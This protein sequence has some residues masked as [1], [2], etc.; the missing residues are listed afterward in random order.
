MDERPASADIG[1]TDSEQRLLDHIRAGLVDAEIAVRLGITNAEVKSRT[2]R[3]AT[4]LR[5]SGRDG[6]KHGLESAEAV[7]FAAPSSLESTPRRLQLFAGLG[8]LGI[9]VAVG[10]LVAIWA[11]QA[12]EDPPAAAARDPSSDSVA[13]TATPRPL[14]GPT[15]VDGRMMYDLGPLFV[16]ENGVEPVA[17]VDTREASVAIT[18]QRGTRLALVSPA[19]TWIVFG[20]G[21]GVLQASAGLDAG[22]RWEL[23]IYADENTV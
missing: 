9:L 6:L 18:L 7:D 22:T 1:L 19:V 11:G 13:P 12:D 10:S 5:V 3:L 15:A 14:R 4:K 17:E 21:P 16:H 2:E 20:S 8:G 23:I